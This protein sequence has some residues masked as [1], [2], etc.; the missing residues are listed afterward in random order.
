M[1]RQF[2]EAHCGDSARLGESLLIA[3]HK[4]E[5]PEDVAQSRN[6]H[7]A[8]ESVRG[9]EKAGTPILLSS[10]MQRGVAFRAKR[11]QV[12]L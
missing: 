12:L 5:D 9:H 1:G 10:A 7:G 6:D 8:L 2:G 4:R 3:V 11:N